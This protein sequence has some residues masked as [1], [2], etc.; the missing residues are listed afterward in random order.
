MSLNISHDGQH[1]SLLCEL[2]AQITMLVTVG[3]ACAVAIV[4]CAFKVKL[5]KVVAGGGVFG[6]AP[7]MLK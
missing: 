1:S 7:K 4:E 2:L 3:P 5:E 6:K